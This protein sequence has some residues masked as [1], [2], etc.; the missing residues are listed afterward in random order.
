MDSQN[1]R[2]SSRSS[3]NN[4]H[5]PQHQRGTPSI[6]PSPPSGSSNNSNSSSDRSIRSNRSISASNQHVSPPQ[7]QSHVHRDPRQGILQHPDRHPQNNQIIFNSQ[8]NSPQPQSSNNPNRPRSSLKNQPLRKQVLTRNHPPPNPHRNDY[9]HTRNSQHGSH[10]HPQINSLNHLNQPQSSQMLR[11]SQYHN[12]PSSTPQPNSRFNSRL[13]FNHQNH[14]LP[15]QIRPHS[16]S[17]PSHMS[18]YSPPVRPHSSSLPSKPH[19][20]SLAPLP[21]LPPYR[22]IGQI[23]TPSQLQQRPYSNQSFL[24][25]PSPLR[26]EELGQSGNIPLVGHNQVKLNYHASD[27]SI[28]RIKPIGDFEVPKKSASVS[29]RSGD[30]HGI[31]RS[32]KKNEPLGMKDLR[33]HLYKD[34]SK[35]RRN[36]DDGPFAVN[37][38]NNLYPP[39]NRPGS[40]QSFQRAPLSRPSSVQSHR[41][42][43]VERN[44]SNLSVIVENQSL[45]NT[46]QQRQQPRQSSNESGANT[47]PLPQAPNLKHKN[48][49]ESHNSRKNSINPESP[50]DSLD[51]DVYYSAALYLENNKHFESDSDSTIHN[52]QTEN[53]ESTAEK[54]VHENNHQNVDNSQPSQPNNDVSTEKSKEFSKPLPPVNLQT[55]SCSAL[56]P[57]KEEPHLEKNGSDKPH[58]RLSKS[59]FSNSITSNTANTANKPIVQSEGVRQIQD[60]KAT[61]STGQDLPPS[62]ALAKK[63]GEKNKNNTALTEHSNKLSVDIP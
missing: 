12:Y 24:L 34:H 3:T 7:P 43:S 50:T 27:P 62:L 51:S 16:S 2:R 33:E 35:Q 18:H 45:P 63:T 4:R 44:P 25:K 59:D 6:I 15:N 17:Q 26:R 11:I 58:T 22:R 40:A 14:S 21:P 41:K 32:S 47:R 55:P 49:L 10:Q 19:N 42:S 30:I 29:G 13:N 36:L 53:I 31:P 39:L 1:N 20:N 52:Q 38:N 60:I 5:H 61:E 48:S 37:L 28:T 57:V 46:H 8:H 54:E 23:V 56:P 9:N